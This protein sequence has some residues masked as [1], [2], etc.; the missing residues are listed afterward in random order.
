MP[1]EYPLEPE[2]LE[3]AAA[4]HSKDLKKKR[5]RATRAL[6]TRLNRS[7]GNKPFLEVITNPELKAAVLAE[8]AAKQGIQAICGRY[9]I[10]RPQYDAICAIEEERVRGISNRREIL[11]RMTPEAKTALQSVAADE[12]L[13]R[14]L[15]DENAFNAAR[16]AQQHK[17]G[18]GDYR[19]VTA[20]RP[21]NMF[22]NCSVSIVQMTDEELRKQIQERRKLLLTAGVDPEGNSG[23]RSNGTIAGAPRMPSQ[24]QV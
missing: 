16:I 7:N 15:E 3:I 23:T 11:L 1:K 10:T 13:M 21:A 6:T 19:S 5:D 14:G 22:E 9:Q 18:T 20:E 24:N 4:I 12:A 17:K 2:E 8:V